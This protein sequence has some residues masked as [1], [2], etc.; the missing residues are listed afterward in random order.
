MGVERISPPEHGYFWVY[1]GL[2]GD[3]IFDWQT[4]REHRHAAEWLGPDLEGV[5]QSY[6]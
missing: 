1:R 3:V 5:L 2:A 6:G 4:S